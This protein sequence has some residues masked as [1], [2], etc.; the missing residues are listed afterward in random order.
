MRIVLAIPSLSQTLAKLCLSSFYDCFHG[1][2][3]IWRYVISCNNKEYLDKYILNS[4]EM[5]G[6]PDQYV[7][8]TRQYLI[9]L[10]F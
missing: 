8:P 6:V 10:D 2:G 1:D 4:C 9:A 5:R 7:N 3:N